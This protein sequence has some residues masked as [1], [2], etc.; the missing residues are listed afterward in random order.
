MAATHDTATKG[1]TLQATGLAPSFTADDLERSLRFYTNGL[2]F[3]IVDRNEMEGELV[4]CMLRAGSAQLGIGQDDWAKG[5]DRAK[6]VGM[7][8][9]ITTEQDIE[10]LAARARA[11]GIALDEDPA[12]LPWGPMAFAV[13]DP[14]GFKLTIANPR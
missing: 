3:E 11:A 8:I 10:A 5:R 12:P 13:T 1:I 4:F 6:G 9:F 7:R 14:D 2:G